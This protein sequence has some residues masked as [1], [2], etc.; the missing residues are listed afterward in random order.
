VKKRTE[1]GKKG[2]K[3][4]SEGVDFVALIQPKISAGYKVKIESEE[5]AGEYT[6]QDVT[7]DGSTY[8]NNWYIS[9]FA[10]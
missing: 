7:I 4:I 10:V 3:T 6:V 9:G 1:K 5:V 8:S 2:K